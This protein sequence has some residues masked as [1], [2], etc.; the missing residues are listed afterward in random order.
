MEESLELRLERVKCLGNHRAK[1]LEAFQDKRSIADR[2]LDGSVALHLHVSTG[3]N[4]LCNLWV[5]SDHGG[6]S[7]RSQ[8]PVFVGIGQFDETLHPVTSFERLELLERCDVFRD[9]GFKM[10]SSEEFSEVFFRVCDRKLCI[11]YYSLGIVA[12]EFIDQILQCGP[13]VLNNFPNKP[14]KPWRGRSA[15][16]RRPTNGHLTETPIYNNGSVLILKGNAISY[17]LTEVPNLRLKVLQAFACPND[18]LIRAF[19]SVHESFT[20]PSLPTDASQ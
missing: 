7:R 20:P 9:Q 12:G 15:E 8:M 2:Y 10:V 17:N 5:N 16:A 4:L 6:T 18:S 11:V 13:Q 1:L 3:K 14:T 19:Q